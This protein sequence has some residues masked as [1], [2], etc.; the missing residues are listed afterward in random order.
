MSPV[1]VH[2]VVAFLLAQS[3]GHLSMS[4]IHRLT[5]FAQ[6]WHLAWTN[7]PLFDEEI[8]I[9]KS[10]PVTHALFPHQTDGYTQETWPAGDASAI[11]GVTAETLLAV[12]G[13]YGHL[14]GIG[15]GEIAHQ[16]SPCISAMVRKTDEDTEPVIDLTELKAFFKALNDAPDDRIAYANRFMDRYTDE[17]LQVRT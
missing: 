10:G 8:R 4:T 11:T 7:T 12:F 3:S 14:P 9:R 6:G 16:H 2:D 1:S 13:S 15:L 17:A 5:Y